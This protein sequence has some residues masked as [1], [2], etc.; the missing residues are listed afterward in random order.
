MIG[1]RVLDASAVTAFVGQR[2]V[3]ASALVWTATEEDIVL[4]I[5]ASALLEVRAGIDGTAE[6]VLA[7]LLGL[8]VTVVDVLDAERAREAGGLAVGDVASAHAAACALGRG[9]P[10]VTAEPARSSAIRG[11]VVEELP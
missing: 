6:A 5:P 9:W 4:V 1:G 7:V 8:P 3:Y 10:L 2:S 11:L